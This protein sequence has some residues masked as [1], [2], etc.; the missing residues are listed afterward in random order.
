MS[1]LTGAWSRYATCPS[2]RIRS[3]KKVVE[4][5]LLLSDLKKKKD[6]NE[7]FNANSYAGTCAEMAPDLD[8]AD[9]LFPRFEYVSCTMSTLELCHLSA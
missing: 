9:T 1:L 2:D 8:T 3:W 7:E 5:L 4:V 6:Q